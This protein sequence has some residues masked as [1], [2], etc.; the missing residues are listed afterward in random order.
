MSY[1]YRIQTLVESIKLLD[2]Q[3]ADANC[4]ATTLIELNDRK[5]EYEAEIRR[6]NRLQWEEDTQRVNLDDDR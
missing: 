5:R 1:R 4:T 3:I 6:L 2:V